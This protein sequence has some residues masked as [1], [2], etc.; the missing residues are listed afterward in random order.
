VGILLGMKK[1]QENQKQLKY[2]F[3]GLRVINNFLLK[4]I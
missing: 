4:R 1:K 2:D 3:Q